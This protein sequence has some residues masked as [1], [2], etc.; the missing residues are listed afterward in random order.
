[1]GRERELAHKASHDCL[2]LDQLQRQ[3]AHSMV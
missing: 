2:R 1:V 3:L